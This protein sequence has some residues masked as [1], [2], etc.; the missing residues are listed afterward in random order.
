MP[1]RG[2][3]G[4]YTSASEQPG[5]QG[6]VAKFQVTQPSTIP[7]PGLGEA[8]SSE[9]V[10][11]PEAN[12]ELALL[13]RSNCVE[14]SENQSDPGNRIDTA[15]GRYAS[16]ESR[17]GPSNAKTEFTWYTSYILSHGPMNQSRAAL[18]P[19]R[20][21][22]DS[23][24]N[25]SPVDNVNS[26]R[27]TES[28][29]RWPSPQVVLSLLQSYFDRFHIHFPVLSRAAITT[30]VQEKTVS[31]TLL[32]SV[33][34]VSV[35]HC[36]IGQIHR[37]GFA[38]RIDAQ[39]FF[40]QRASNAFDTDKTSDQTALMLAAFHLHFW[41]GDPA[42]HRD[43]HWWLATAI[44]FSQCLKYHRRSYGLGRVAASQRKRVWWCLFV[45]LLGPA[46][47]SPLIS[48]IRDR[49]VALST[50]NPALIH[51]LEFDVDPLHAYDL[52]DIA[53]IP[54]KYLI[55][56]SELCTTGMCFVM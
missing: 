15:T 35:I 12:P 33:L 13:F 56:Q 42:A 9:S 8:L 32:F 49:Q 7:D 27:T 5:I 34:Y 28:P 50:G 37:M 25:S 41:F 4:R 53:A 20:L 17:S 36:D 10:N 47:R 16:T 24:G 6:D 30:A 11:E 18:A 22:T 26:S 45:S 43:G 51:D 40:F 1:F 19:A 54:S 2:A 55:L 46:E 29:D 23:I 39:T 52:A 21:E 48:Q 14:E 38:T 44:R 3:R 31:Q